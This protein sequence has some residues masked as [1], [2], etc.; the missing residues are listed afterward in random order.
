MTNG[1]DEHTGMAW[2]DEYHHP[3]F[4]SQSGDSSVIDT[5]GNCY[6]CGRPLPTHEHQEPHNV[7]VHI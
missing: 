5:K 6:R 7:A 2:I 4:G 1:K 3:D